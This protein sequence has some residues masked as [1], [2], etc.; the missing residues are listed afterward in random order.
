MTNRVVNTISGRLSL[1]APQRE[2]LEALAATIAASP[3]MLNPKRDVPMLLET[4][5][6]EFPKLSDFEREFPSLCFAFGM[7]IK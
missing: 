4:L 1:R 2:S 5:K 3:D 6:G 7:C